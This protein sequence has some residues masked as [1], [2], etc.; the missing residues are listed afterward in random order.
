MSCLETSNLLDIYIKIFQAQK[1]SFLK[2]LNSYFKVSSSF[3]IQYFILK[4]SHGEIK[5][6]LYIRQKFA[7]QK[8]IR[9][10]PRVADTAFAQTA[11]G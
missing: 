5:V 4:F 1:S 7:I 9:V 11:V 3:T 6:K 2:F 10:F 8:L